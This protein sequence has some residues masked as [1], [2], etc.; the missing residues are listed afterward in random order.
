MARNVT[1]LLGAGASYE[2]IPLVKSIPEGLKNFKTFLTENIDN[3]SQVASFNKTI[4]QSA[5]VLLKEFIADLNWLQEK[6][7]I[8]SSID[9][10][11]KKLITQKK[12]NDLEILKQVLTLYF[13]FIQYT[14]YPDKRY[15]SFIASLIDHN[16]GMLPDNV[17]ILSWNYDSQFEFSMSE[18]CQP[19]DFNST[20][21][22]LN[23]FPR[24]QIAD[25]NY[26]I[27]SL[28]KLNGSAVFRNEASK[29]RVL[30]LNKLA[31][32]EKMDVMSAVLESYKIW[33]EGN[34]KSEITFSWENTKETNET[35]AHA[36]SAINSTNIL[37]VIGYSFPFFNRI[38]DRAI[39]GQMKYLG[40]VYIQAPQSDINNIVESFKSIKYTS[41]NLIELITE[42]SQFFLPPEL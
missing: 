21:A 10:F 32:G 22:R 18:F 35:H 33:K 29:R 8:H 16:T 28:F 20:Q 23:V 6:S 40:K 1:Y 7:L 9:T 3:I 14:K 42:V 25:R 27:F 39:I 34:L 2:V 11:A 19:N 31:I 13:Q 15:D 38:I 26:N 37:V 24:N 41:G 17:K 36:M 30:I 5:R 12:D 4:G